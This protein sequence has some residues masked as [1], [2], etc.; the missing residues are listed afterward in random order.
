MYAQLVSSC[1]QIPSQGLC[2]TYKD[3]P[4]RCNQQDDVL[5]VSHH[6]H[7]HLPHHSNPLHHHPQGGFCFQRSTLTILS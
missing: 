3:E 4:R 7:P 1:T 2:R 6:P 5:S